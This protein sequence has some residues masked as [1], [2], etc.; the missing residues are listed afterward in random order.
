MIVSDDCQSFAIFNYPQYGIGWVGSPEAVI[1]A[2]AITHM[3]SGTPAVKGIS[4]QDQRLVY[5]LT[6]TGCSARLRSKTLCRNNISSTNVPAYENI[7]LVQCPAELVSVRSYIVMSPFTSLQA[8][9]C[10]R[11]SPVAS[12]DRSYSSVSLVLPHPL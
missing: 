2:G 6:P 7:P 5:R 4:S 9:N 3:L 10:Y 12:A 8:S 1:A 11:S